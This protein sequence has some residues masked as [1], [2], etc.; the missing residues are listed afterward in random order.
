MC[1]KGFFFRLL[2]ICTNDTCKVTGRSAEKL[3]IRRRKAN[4]R[5]TSLRAPSTVN[6]TKNVN[7]KLSSRPS[8][9]KLSFLNTLDGVGCLCSKNFL[10]KSIRTW[11]VPTK[12]AAVRQPSLDKTHILRPSAKL[13]IRYKFSLRA[14]HHWHGETVVIRF[15]A[16]MASY[17]IITAP[18]IF[19]VRFF[20][21][22][23]RQK[24]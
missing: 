21:N 13:D 12:I 23:W 2:I 15:S 20:K 17:A 10:Q 3:L 8:F 11:P 16:E 7:G 4:Y 9:E 1:A 24:H 5:K 6:R 19:H 22:S 18:Y 14:I